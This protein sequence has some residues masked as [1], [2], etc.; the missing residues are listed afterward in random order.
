VC[1]TGGARFIGLWLVK[2]LLERGYTVHATLRN[3]GAQVLAAE[4]NVDMA[5]VPTTH[6]LVDF[7]S[8]RRLV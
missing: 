8:I 1:V 2:K 4:S 7:S 6:N 5:M 3:T